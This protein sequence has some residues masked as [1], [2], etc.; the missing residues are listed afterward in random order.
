VTKSAAI[1]RADMLSK[2]SLHSCTFKCYRFTRF[3]LMAIAATVPQT[4]IPFHFHAE[5]EEYAI[6]A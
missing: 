3:V 1:A 5:S 4:F 6:L 2:R